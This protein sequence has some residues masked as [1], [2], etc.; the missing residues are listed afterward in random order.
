M[1]HHH[2]NYLNA[3]C[4]TQLI[5]KSLERDELLKAGLGVE[6]LGGT[7]KSQVGKESQSLQTS[8]SSSQGFSQAQLE[9][10]SAKEELPQ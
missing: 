10:L 1:Y 9:H 5:G 7:C 2:D 4:V 3:M 8:V 6:Q